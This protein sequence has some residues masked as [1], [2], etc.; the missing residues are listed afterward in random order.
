M[1]QKKPMWKY[2]YNAILLSPLID[3]ILQKKSDKK[4]N[5]CQKVI[6]SFISQKN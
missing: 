6:L 4:I 2:R 3:T 1:L 5:P